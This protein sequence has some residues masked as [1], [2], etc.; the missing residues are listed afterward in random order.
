M[1]SIIA[2]NTIRFIILLLVQV[3]VLNHINFLGYI[4]PYVY[5]LF[6]LLFPIINN[7]MLFLFLSFLLGLLI[8]IFSDTG[9]IHAAASVTIAFLRPAALKFSFGAAYEHQSV[10]FNAIDA[11]QR[12]TY[13]TILI[14]IHHLILF[15]LE[16]FNLSK[17]ILILK[18]T[19][20]SCIFTLLLCVLVTILFGRTSK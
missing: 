16:I 18:N 8:D 7:R 15:V 13:M 2:L 5:L 9:G 12:L 3:L 1:N 10:K 17:V 19:L 20:F 11:G 14:T 6:I 4:N